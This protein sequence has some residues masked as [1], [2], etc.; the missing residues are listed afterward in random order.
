[1]LNIQPCI[2]CH[3]SG[4]VVGLT[5]KESF[6][7]M[8]LLRRADFNAGANVNT[9]WRMP[10]RGAQDVASKKSLTWDNKQITWFGTCLWLSL[11]L[12]SS[13]AQSLA[14]WLSLA[15]SLALLAPSL[16]ACLCLSL[17]PSL[18]HSLSL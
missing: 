1:M 13:L 18:A 3:S 16:S 12:S 17:A 4:F 9:F 7:G 11:F 10:C 14:L 5:A 2:A 15:L 6:G 8:R